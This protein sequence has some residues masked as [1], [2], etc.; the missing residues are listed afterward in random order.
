[1]RTIVKHLGHDDRAAETEQ[2]EPDAADVER[3]GRRLVK[4]RQVVDLVLACAKL[5]DDAD[6]LARAID[7]K[8][9]DDQ[10]EPGRRAKQER[11]L[12]EMEVVDVRRERLDEVPPG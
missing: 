5:L 8:R 12:R 3:P 4:N 10:L 2:A 7:N 11:K 1:M 9:R 6:V